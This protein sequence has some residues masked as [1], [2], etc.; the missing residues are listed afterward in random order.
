MYALTLAW[1]WLGQWRAPKY[2]PIADAL[3]HSLFVFIILVHKH[4][5]LEKYKN[6]EGCVLIQVSRWASTYYLF[7]RIKI[8]C[9][10]LKNYVTS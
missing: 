4:L 2:F 6:D 8:S 5:K 7:Y 3:V 1:N 10:D 9:N